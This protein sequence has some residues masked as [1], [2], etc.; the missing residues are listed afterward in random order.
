MRV[1]I[2]DDTESVR[3]ALCLVMEHLGHSVVGLARDGAEALEKYQLTRPEVVLMD[4][5]MPKLDGLKSTTLLIERDPKARVLMLT[6]GRTTVQVARQA[7]AFGLL[8]KPFDIDALAA[9]V[10][11]VG[12]S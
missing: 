3:M 6:G 2:V 7:G 1:L 11:S 9:L 4:V 12:N 8:E 5:R 10:N